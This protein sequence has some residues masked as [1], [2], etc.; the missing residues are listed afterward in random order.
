MSNE[1]LNNP[2]ARF[3]AA[4]SFATG[5][6]QA[7]IDEGGYSQIPTPY[8]PEIYANEYFNLVE[9]VLKLVR[10]T[11]DIDLLFSD[12]I[13]IAKKRAASLNEQ[14]IENGKVTLAK[15]LGS[16]PEDMPDADEYE[17]IEHL[18]EQT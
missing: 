17:K 18:W 16:Y 12:L 6:F 14:A 7:Q 1:L 15:E 2:E 3:H 5:E 13:E 11:R 9:H 8:F 4:I 10:N